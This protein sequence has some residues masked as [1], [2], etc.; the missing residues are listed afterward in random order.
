ILTLFRRRSPFTILT[1]PPPPPVQPSS[2]SPAFSSFWVV[3]IVSSIVMPPP[4]DCFGSGSRLFA[5]AGRRRNAE[6]VTSQP[7]ALAVGPLNLNV[8]NR[9][10]HAPPRA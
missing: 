3:V 7:S 10:F 8:S 4:V 9:F 1:P 2:P 6:S 5:R